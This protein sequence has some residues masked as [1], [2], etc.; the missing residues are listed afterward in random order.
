MIGYMMDG[1]KPSAD[2]ASVRMFVLLP[3]AGQFL[4][5]AHRIPNQMVEV[6]PRKPITFRDRQLV[7]ARGTLNRTTGKPGDEKASWAMGD[8]EVEPAEP[9][10]ISKWFEP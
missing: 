3:E 9:R 5:P 6:R 10:D 2:G 4:H 1:Y 8:A 7:W